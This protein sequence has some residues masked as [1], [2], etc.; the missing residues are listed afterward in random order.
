MAMEDEEEYGKGYEQDDPEDNL[1]L[2]D[3]IPPIGIREL[4]DLFNEQL[5]NEIKSLKCQHLKLVRGWIVFDESIHSPVLNVQSGD[6]V[7]VYLTLS[8]FSD[9]W[10]RVTWKMIRDVLDRAD[11]ARLQRSVS[12][13]DIRKHIEAKVQLHKKAGFSSKIRTLENAT[14]QNRIM[15]TIVELLPDNCYDIRIKRTSEIVV[16]SKNNKKLVYRATVN[17]KFEEQAIY[18]GKIDVARQV[19]ES[20]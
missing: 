2:E 15:E 1:E 5:L 14:D 4:E 17:S 19:L 12:L 10:S 7:N 9:L 8:D 3:S 18:E 20:D 16:T 6:V 11:R 13:L